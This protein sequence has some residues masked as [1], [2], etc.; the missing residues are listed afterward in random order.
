MKDNQALRHHVI[1]DHVHDELR[2]LWPGFIPFGRV[3]M[4]EG[5]R[6]MGKSLIAVDVM[7]RVSSGR[8]MPDGTPCAAGAGVMLCADGIAETVV[9]RLEAA[10]ADLGRIVLL[11][12]TPQRKIVLPRDVIM[13]A[14]HV[15]AV[16]AKLLVIDP[17]LAYLDPD[18]N[19]LSPDELE[20]ATAPLDLLAVAS[21]VALMVVRRL[22]ETRDTRSATLSV[23]N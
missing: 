10:G 11:E 5:S 20:I 14:Q 6:G 12:S 23:W 9:P 3:T 15:V 8:P 2:W 4:L 21:D 19:P 17:L 22:D 7:A 1:D 13:L 16:R 18:V